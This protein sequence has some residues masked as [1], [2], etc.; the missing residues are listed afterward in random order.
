MLGA[1]EAS[2]ALYLYTAEPSMTAIVSRDAQGRQQLIT[3]E[4]WWRAQLKRQMAAQDLPISKDEAI[5]A[6]AAPIGALGLELSAPEI[7]V[8]LLEQVDRLIAIGLELSAPDFGQ[9]T[10]QAFNVVGSTGIEIGSPDLGASTTAAVRSEE[11]KTQAD[12]TIA[13]LFGFEN[14][15]ADWDGNEAAKP[16]AFSIKD[17]REFIR[18]LAPESI[19]P[20]P[21]L[22]ADGHAILFIRGPESYAE[23]EFLGARR[24]GFYVRRGEQEWSDEFYFDGRAIPAGLLQIGF[25]I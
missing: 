20:R 10:A 24:I 22:H 16:L 5:A 17:A 18:A 11:T 6:E 12:R 21:A 8:E 23:L 9:P 25:A 1:L 19:I 14:L 4:M 3:L 15:N 2:T 13:Q 7:G